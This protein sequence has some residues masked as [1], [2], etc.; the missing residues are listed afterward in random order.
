MFAIIRELADRVALI[1]VS[2]SAGAD[3][4]CR[5]LQDLRRRRSS[6][7]PRR[8]SGVLSP[9][10]CMARETGHQTPITAIGTRCGDFMIVAVPQIDKNEKEKTSDP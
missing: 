7:A 9:G 2:R 8:V 5:F 1:G 6:R 3:R 4:F 10:L